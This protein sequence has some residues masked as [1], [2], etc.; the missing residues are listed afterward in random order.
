LF[1]SPWAASL[2]AWIS[3]GVKV[4]FITDFREAPAALDHFSPGSL[5]TAGK[6]PSRLPS[7]QVWT[8]G[9]D[10]APGLDFAR[11]NQMAPDLQGVLCPFLRQSKSLA[12]LADQECSFLWSPATTVSPASIPGVIPVCAAWV[13][14]DFPMRVDPHG[15]YTGVSPGRPRNPAVASPEVVLDVSEGAGGR[16]PDDET[17]LAF[18]GNP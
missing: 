17:S 11:P 14:G 2:N 8:G 10:G 1:T 9:A 5:W 6:C 18:P 13:P 4:W 12:G 16:G 7:T 15:R 3:S